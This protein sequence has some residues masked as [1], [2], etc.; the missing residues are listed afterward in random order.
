MSCVPRPS[1]ISRNRTFLGDG[2]YRL[3]GNYRTETRTVERIGCVAKSQTAEFI[4]NWEELRSGLSTLIPEIG[5]R[6]WVACWMYP[7]CRQSGSK[8]AG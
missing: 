5:S 8:K 1:G 6:V 3:F 2:A 4:R 7:S